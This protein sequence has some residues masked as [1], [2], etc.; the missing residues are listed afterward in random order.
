MGDI[1][2]G[3]ALKNPDINPDVLTALGEEGLP[4][5]I[6]KQARET[7]DTLDGLVLN[8]E[9]PAFDK[10][11]SYWQNMQRQFTD[12]YKGPDGGEVQQAGIGA[13]FHEAMTPSSV[14]GHEVIDELDEI[15]MGM[16]R[17]G[18]TEGAEYKR[19]LDSFFA[20]VD[21]SQ[22]T[23]AQQ[24]YYHKYKADRYNGLFMRTSKNRIIAKVDAL[25]KGVV[26]GNPTV[27]MGNFIEPVIKGVP[28]YGPNFFKGLRNL[29][30]EHGMDGLFKEIP[31]LKEQGIYGLD[32]GDVAP[33]Q[34][35]IMGLI[36]AM[37]RPSKNLMYYVGMA[38]EGTA[39]GG[40]RAVQ[41]VLFLPTLANTPLV[42]RT[43]ESRAAVRLLSYSIG[44]MQLMHDV[45]KSAVTNPSPESVSRL[46]GLV[47]TY[48]VITG[49][50]AYWASQGED[51]GDIPIIGNVWKT[52]AAVSGV[53]P[54]SRI[55][56]PF[57][58]FNTAIL[59]PPYKAVQKMFSDPESLTAKDIW[60]VATAFA[61]MGAAPGSGMEAL[62]SNAQF[63][64]AVTA[65]LE[66]ITGEKEA[67]QAFAEAFIPGAKE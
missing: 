12:N 63:K 16:L 22:Y 43:P 30:D 15:S 23:P 24:I 33:E 10:Q 45:V 58:I 64:K 57:N 1:V 39:A 49:L 55:G 35:G 21:T 17:E 56:I 61:F 14:L 60:G 67:G 41:D 37:D 51:V 50:P 53:S 38:K 36:S 52:A 19:R 34:G 29:V 20:T 62:A 28:M 26:I 32:I 48:S 13:V 3:E 42:Y 66:T 40:R 11:R 4:S 2:G 59:A 9:K 54:V 6:A 46:A 44:T 5:F 7:A 27:L 65:S 47:G 18:I 8:Y 31:A 25:S